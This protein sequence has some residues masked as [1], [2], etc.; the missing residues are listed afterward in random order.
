MIHGLH[1]IKSGK[2][3][4][5]KRTKTQVRN[6]IRDEG[7]FNGFIC[8]NKVN[9]WHIADGWRLGVHINPKTIDQFENSVEKFETG[10][11]VYT[12]ELGEYAHYYRI[13]NTI[14]DDKE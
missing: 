3:E 4:L 1:T 13:V 6:I 11:R 12:P 10:L 7:E 2:Y 14:E 9:P 8:G 5:Q